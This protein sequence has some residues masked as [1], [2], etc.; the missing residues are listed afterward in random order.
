VRTPRGARSPAGRP[1]GRI[2]SW[3]TNA[4]AD[5]ATEVVSYAASPYAGD[6]APAGI[7]RWPTDVDGADQLDRRPPRGCVPEPARPNAPGES[8]FVTEGR[9]LTL[10]LLASAYT[11][12]SVFVAEPFADEFAA[13]VPH[14]VPLYVAPKT[15][16]S[17]VVGFNFHLGVLG[18]GRRGRLPTLDGLLGRTPLDG[19]LR[20]VICPETTKPENLGLIFRSAAGFDVDGIV[21][22]E[23]CCDPF[24]RRALRLSMGGVLQVPLSKSADLAEDVRRLKHHWGVELVAAVLDAQ[25]AR[26]PGIRWPRRTALV[27]GNEYYGI[28]RPWLSQCDRL[29][30][31]PMKPGVDSLNLGVAAGI[32]LY[33]MTKATTGF[34]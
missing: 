13:V 2:P 4:L 25:A 30:T 14:D 3:P 5:L 31:I 9:T 20:L 16:L 33:E 8:V 28:R 1:A 6:R 26:L 22:G 17:G 27:F 12:D 19:L 18:S 11:T 34:R 10:R 32:F 21:L 23:R 24:S 29:V 15:V 7:C